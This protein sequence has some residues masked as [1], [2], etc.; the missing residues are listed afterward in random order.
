VINGKDYVPGEYYNNPVFNSIDYFE[1]DPYSARH[2]LAVMGVINA[3]QNGYGTVGMNPG[4]PVNYFSA[5]QH[6]PWSGDPPHNIY[7]DAAFDNAFVHAESAR[8]FPVLNFSMNS[9]FPS[10][11]PVQFDALSPGGLAF[12]RASR[13]F[14]ITQSAGNDEQDACN[15]AYS[16]NQVNEPNDG[17]MVVGG[18]NRSGQQ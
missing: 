17:I 16:Y 3:A 10:S 6:M 8:T 9:E 12:R 4:Q 2:G 1:D 14:M 13:R 11:A 15:Y 5:I 7:Y 18:L